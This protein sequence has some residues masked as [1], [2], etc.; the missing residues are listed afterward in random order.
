MKKGDRQVVHSALEATKRSASG[1][2]TRN[3]SK[4]EAKKRKADGDLLRQEPQKFVKTNQGKKSAKQD[5]KEQAVKPAAVS[6]SIITNRQTK[7]DP[8]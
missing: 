2:T 6:K 5:A 1:P 4:T 7:T 3:S 8:S